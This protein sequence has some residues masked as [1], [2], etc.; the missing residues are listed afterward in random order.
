MRRKRVRIYMPRP[1]I[2]QPGVHAWGWLLIALFF[3]LALAYMGWKIY[4]LGDTQ[5][6]RQNRLVTLRTEEL[7]ERIERIS[8]ERDQLRQQ[9]ASLAMFQ[10]LLVT[11]PPQSPASPRS[12]SRWMFGVRTRSLP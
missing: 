9:V 11:P 1:A 5:L 2:Q 10:P 12:A 8:E 6:M 4:S 3:T 7:E